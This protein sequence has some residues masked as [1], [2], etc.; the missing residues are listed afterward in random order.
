MKIINDFTSEA[1]S[2]SDWLDP[3]NTQQYLSNHW[4][5]HLTS[6][7]ARITP[8]TLV[9]L[10]APLSENILDTGGSPDPAPSVVPENWWLIPQPGFNEVGTLA[11]SAAMYD[12]HSRSGHVFGHGILPTVEARADFPEVEIS[13]R[14]LSRKIGYHAMCFGEGPRFPKAGIDQAVREILAETDL[15]PMYNFKPIAI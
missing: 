4:G 3:W 11:P 14:K 10:E 2:I 8:Q 5:F 9:A 13:S 12:P 7:S 6:S 1:G 15:P